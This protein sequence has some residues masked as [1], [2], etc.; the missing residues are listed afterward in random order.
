MD[1]GGCS[2]GRP[3]SYWRITT[4]HLHDC[5]IGDGLV[6]CLLLGLAPGLVVIVARYNDHTTTLEALKRAGLPRLGVREY[7]RL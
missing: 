5:L 7:V 2:Y 6:A 4:F 1:E 3:S